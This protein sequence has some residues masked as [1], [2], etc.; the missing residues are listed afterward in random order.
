M[1]AAA[2]FTEEENRCITTVS[3][4]LGS[5]SRVNGVQ[6][7]LNIIKEAFG[8]LLLFPTIIKKNKR[9]R[10]VLHNKIIEFR[11]GEIARADNE[12]INMSN[13]LIGIISRFNDDEANE[14]AN[15]ANNNANNDNNNNDDGNDEALD[16]NG[17]DD[18]DENN[19]EDEGDDYY[20]MYHCE[21]F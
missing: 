16:E 11:T 15:D 9:F 13:V 14:E 19:Y 20:M 5:A 10:Y 17:E 12:F 3:E 7:K 8:H 6:N 18:E 21:R 1:A 2:L 4:L